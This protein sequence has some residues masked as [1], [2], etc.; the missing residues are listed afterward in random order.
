MLSRGP[1]GVGVR[2]PSGS[3]ALPPLGGPRAGTWATFWPLVASPLPQAAQ[4]LSRRTRTVCWMSSQ[5]GEAKVLKWLLE[6][7][8]GLETSVCPPDGPGSGPG[9]LRCWGGGAE[10]GLGVELSRPACRAPVGP[11]AISL[12]PGGASREVGR[13]GQGPWQPLLRGWSWC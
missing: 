8:V 2:S 10:T 11:V 5:H 4:P 6:N 3:W 13:M 12:C 7:C 9:T 1:S